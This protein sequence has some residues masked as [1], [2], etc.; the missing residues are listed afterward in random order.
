ML[1]QFKPTCTPQRDDD[2]ED[3]NGDLGAIPFSLSWAIQQDDNAVRVNKDD[4]EVCLICCLFFWCDRVKEKL[5]VPL[6][7]FYQILICEW[8]VDST[9]YQCSMEEQ[10]CISALHVRMGLQYIAIVPLVLS[11]F[12]RGKKIL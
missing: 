1:L 5:E 3:S 12:C 4:K 10:N 6:A 9:E 11:H 2:D 8:S 7:F